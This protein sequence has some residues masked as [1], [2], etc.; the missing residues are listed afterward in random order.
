M[1]ALDGKRI[2]LLVTNY[3]VEEAE[4][5]APRQAVEDAGGDPVIVAV[6][7]SPVQSLVGDKD[8][9]RSFTPDALI[10]KVSADEFDALIIPGGTINADK[11]R[12]EEDGIDLVAAFIDA[13]KPVAAICHGP[14]ALVETGQLAE[15]TLTSYPSLQTDI[16]NAG[17]DWVDE[18]VQVDDVGG[19]T[20]VTS[21]TP[22]DMEDFTRELVRVFAETPS[23]RQAEE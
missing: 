9:G 12:L 4:L 10:G 16:I 8:P 2:A 6:E 15:K 1:P 13:G 19:W 23:S 17:A 7:D 22:D 11:L 18:P 3:G 20:L 21:R 14:W 5:A